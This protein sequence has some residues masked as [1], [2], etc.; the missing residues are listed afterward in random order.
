VV[1]YE[2]LTMVSTRLSVS[3]W[4]LWVAS[5]GTKHFSTSHGSKGLPTYIPYSNTKWSYRGNR[6]YWNI[7]ATAHIQSENS[8]M[9]S[10]LEEYLKKW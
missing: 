8:Y 9:R 5:P 3:C 7:S 6:F 10:T 2:I 4:I 1:L